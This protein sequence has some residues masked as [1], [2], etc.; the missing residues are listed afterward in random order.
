VLREAA[1]QP[2]AAG[3]ACARDPRTSI[4][5]HPDRPGWQQSRNSWAET[6]V[7]TSRPADSTNQCK[8][9]R[10]ATSSF[11][12]NTVGAGFMRAALGGPGAKKKASAGC[13]QEK[14]R[15]GQGPGREHREPY[16]N[17]KAPV[18]KD[19]QKPLGFNLTLKPIDEQTMRKLLKIY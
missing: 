12:T 6:K 9:G 15:D 13:H 2:A 10:T 3:L 16:E 17:T 19:S 11:A 1:P 4:T 7:S 5:K 18:K 8:D 14:S